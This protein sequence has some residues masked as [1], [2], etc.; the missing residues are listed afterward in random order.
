MITR[1]NNNN[2]VRVLSHESLTDKM[3]AISTKRLQSRHYATTR[4]ETHVHNYNHTL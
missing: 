4:T 1:N 3:S 2:C